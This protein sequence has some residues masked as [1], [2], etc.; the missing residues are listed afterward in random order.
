ML[1]STGPRSSPLAQ[2]F[3]STFL[4]A[5]PG[6]QPCVPSCSCL[7]VHLRGVWRVVMP[8]ISDLLGDAGGHVPLQSWGLSSLNCGRRA[9]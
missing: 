5:S 4:L 9:R 3:S 8:F 2:R 7:H 6:L 1:T